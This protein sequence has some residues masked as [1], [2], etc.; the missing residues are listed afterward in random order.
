MENKEHELNDGYISY[1]GLNRPPLI[2][3]IPI[4]SLIAILSSMFFIAFPLFFYVN[5]FVGLTVVAILLLALLAI[6]VM[7]EDDARAMEVVKVKI[8]GFLRYKFKKILA[9]RGN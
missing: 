5:T 2:M 7:C 4:M 8:K 1:N 6:K 9:V 3:G